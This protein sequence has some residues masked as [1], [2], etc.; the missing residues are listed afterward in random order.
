MHTHMEEGDEKIRLTKKH[1]I[2]YI[3]W[4]W[5]RKCLKL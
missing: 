3:L 5:H 4:E 1:Y 2:Y